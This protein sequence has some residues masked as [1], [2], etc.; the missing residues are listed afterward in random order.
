MRRWAQERK[1]YA[2]LPHKLDRAEEEY[3]KALDESL[4]PE[5]E[6]TEELEG[7][8]PLGGEMRVNIKSVGNLNKHDSDNK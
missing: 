5:W 6:Y 3:L 8:T 4:T 2:T 7:D 1:F